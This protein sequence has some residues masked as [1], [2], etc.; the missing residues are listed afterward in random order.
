[1]LVANPK[2][3]EITEKIWKLPEG[4]LNPVVGSHYVKIMRDLED[5]KIKW[6]WV[7]VNN[8][9]QNTANASHW[10]TAARE[11]DNFIVVSE[12]YPGISRKG[13]GPD[14]ACSDDI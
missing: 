1:M 8:P 3:R 4:T 7:Q 11:M 12:A 9:W 6:V 2:H 13:G 5:G 10:I 14:S